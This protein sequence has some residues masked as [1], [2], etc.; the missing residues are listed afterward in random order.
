MTAALGL[1]GPSDAPRPSA[2]HDAGP[3]EDGT[4]PDG[5]LTVIG[6]QIRHLNEDFK[7]HLDA[8]SVEDALRV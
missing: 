6:Q 7:R 1:P 2:P 3:E 8:G 4:E 5:P